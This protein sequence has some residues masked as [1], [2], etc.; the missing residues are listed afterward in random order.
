MQEQ[1][2]R[3]ALLRQMTDLGDQLT[4]LAGQMSKQGGVNAERLADLQA[5]AAQLTDVAD[6]LAQYVDTA[7]DQTAR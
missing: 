1:D 5:L 4:A 6:E 7:G 2:G 3:Q